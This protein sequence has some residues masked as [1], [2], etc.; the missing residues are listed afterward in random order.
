MKLRKKKMMAKQVE[1]N[2]IEVKGKDTF[3]AKLIKAVGKIKNIF[4][5]HLLIFSKLFYVIPNL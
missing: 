1:K 4:F 2:L 5:V 3:F